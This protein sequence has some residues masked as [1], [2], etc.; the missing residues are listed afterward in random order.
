MEITFKPENIFKNEDG[1][2]QDK[3]GNRFTK[4]WVNRYRVYSQYI[5]SYARPD[6]PW[7]LLYSCNTKEDAESLK[8]SEEKQNKKDGNEYPLKFK[9]VD[10]GQPNYYYSLIW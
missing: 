9:V 5:G 2:Y 7:K 4:E 6:E 3:A 8:K 1:D 10:A